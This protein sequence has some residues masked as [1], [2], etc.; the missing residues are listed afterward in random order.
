MAII[1]PEMKG[2][3]L[4]QRRSSAITPA[5]TY[6]RPA[7]VDDMPMK[8]A[9]KFA[10]AAEQL[11]SSLVD[12]ATQYQQ[13]KEKDDLLRVDDTVAAI[14]AEVGSGVPQKVQEH[15]LLADMSTVA[16][17]RVNEAIGSQDAQDRSSQ[18]FE[19]FM[20][21][22]DWMDPDKTRKFIQ[23]R[24]KE[25]ATLAAS[26]PGYGGA[27]YKG[28]TNQLN[29]LEQHAQARRAAY[30]QQKQG[31]EFLRQVIDGTNG[32]VADHAPPAQPA[33]ATTPIS[34]LNGKVVGDKVIIDRHSYG[35]GEGSSD[36]A[37]LI[38]HFEG[39][40]SSTYW[41][42]NHHRVGYGSDTITTPDGKVIEVKPGMTVSKED[43]QRDLQRRTAEFQAGIKRDIGE[44]A[45]NKLS[46]GTQAA[47]TSFAYNYGAGWA[48]KAPS[49]AAA[50][51]SGD[52]MAVGNAILSRRNDNGGVNNK[53]RTQEAQLAAGTADIA[54]IAARDHI[55][56]VDA[57]WG[58][59]SGI[60]NV[61]RRD[62][63]AKGLVD[64]AVKTGDASYLDRMPPEWMTPS[65]Q[66]DFAHARKV[67]EDV[68]WT[69]H[70]RQLE[71]ERQE[72]TQTVDS[73]KSAID[74]KIIA[75]KEIDMGV[76]TRGPDGRVIPEVFDYAK[77]HQAADLS[78]SVL[79]S[80]TNRANLEDKIE[81]AAA[82]GDYSKVDSAWAGKTP[83]P[84]ELRSWIDRQDGMRTQ[85]KIALKRKLDKIIAAGQVVDSP[86]AKRYFT[87]YVGTYA[88][89]QSKAMLPKLLNGLSGEA[90]DFKGE[91]HKV[92]T[93]E[94][95]MRMRDAMEAGGPV[96]K[97]EIFEAAEKKAK[98]HVKDLVDAFSKGSTGKPDAKPEAKPPKN[99]ANTIKFS[100]LPPNAPIR[101]MG[102]KRL[103]KI[104]KDKD[105]IEWKEV[106]D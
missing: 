29:A 42:V 52:G 33:S 69:N 76:D 37:K 106:I 3:Q 72:K 28:V 105:T 81:N 68:Q 58:K 93:N 83:D 46:P 34:V 11:G 44:E 77:A 27:Y 40:R 101:Q 63:L 54:T 84:A 38:A 92:F 56:S 95:R 61:Y 26:N 35:A 41:D 16:R 79:Q 64:I 85:D 65:I 45:W 13:Q 55:R 87:D 6:A 25:A 39:F 12:V 62:V 67:A 78:V 97:R 32:V 89:A 5:D 88:D 103:V 7:P 82:A 73:L 24:E 17:M 51:R 74:E 19:Q 21:T 57:E 30:Y 23:D 96:N 71:R 18:Y 14:R 90:T 20:Q 104:Q 10:R 15:P 86:D 1:T 70:Q 59:S 36:P 50:A 75:G 4:D 8:N 99:Q 98:E 47:L 100:E 49:V 80:D 31:E 2:V 48:K 9:A 22:D 94:V 91:A 60:G 43:A 53:R 66:A 102:G